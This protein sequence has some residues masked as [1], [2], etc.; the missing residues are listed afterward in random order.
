[1][2]ARLLTLLAVGAAAATAQPLA[3]PDAAVSAIYAALTESAA[4]PFSEGAF[5][6]LFLPSARFTVARGGAVRSLTVDEFVAQLQAS[7]V[8]SREER[9]LWR[10]MDRFGNVAQVWTGFE[11]RVEMKD[12]K[13]LTRRGVNSFQLAFD[14]TGWKVNSILWDDERPGQPVP[15]RP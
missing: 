7:P 12:G 4:Q 3:T 1:M 13:T 2:A 9:E 5:R 8:K 10:R 15:E 14:G 11:L 6:A